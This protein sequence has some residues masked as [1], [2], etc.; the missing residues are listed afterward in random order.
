MYDQSVSHD[1]SE[2]N[3]GLPRKRNVWVPSTTRR[4]R[5][6][7]RAK[8][9]TD[10]RMEEDGC[11]TRWMIVAQTEHNRLA[12]VRRQPEEDE[13]P[14]NPKS[15]QQTKRW[16]DPCEKEKAVSCVII[17]YIFLFEYG[18]IGRWHISISFVPVYYTKF[19]NCFCKKM[20]QR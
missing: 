8:P 20:I 11:R 9:K 12:P 1:R 18:L 5:R 10:E 4:R 6:K 3:F 15:T 16:D 7:S 19:S 17:L 2:T 13:G 14:V